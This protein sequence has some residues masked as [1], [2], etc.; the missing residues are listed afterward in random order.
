[1]RLI[2]PSPAICSPAIPS[3]AKA[4]G[5]LSGGDDPIATP[6]PTASALPL[7]LSSPQHH[8]W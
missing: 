1:M 8:R 2:T 4:I 5:T 6:R 3:Q 7:H